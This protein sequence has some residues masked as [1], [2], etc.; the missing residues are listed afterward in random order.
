MKFKASRID[1]TPEFP[2]R[3]TGMKIQETHQ[4]LYSRLEMNAFLFYC[5]GRKVILIGIDTLFISTELKE[6]TLKLVRLH[7]EGIKDEDLILIATHTHFAPS[8]ERKRVGLGACDTVYFEFLCKRMELLLKQL[9]DA[10]FQDVD[11]EV[12]EGRSNGLTC[13]RRRFVRNWRTYF[14]PFI[15]MEPN[16]KGYKNEEFKLI[17]VV[18][19]SALR[20][21]TAL[22]WSFPCHPTNLYDSRLMSSEFP[23]E[24]RK[25]VREKEGNS[26]VPI[27]YLPGFAGDVRAFPPKRFSI[28]KLFRTIF[29]LPYPVKFYRFVDKQEYTNWVNSVELAFN[30]IWTSSSKVISLV[31]ASFETVLVKKDVRKL[32]IQ[33]EEVDELY[34]RRINWGNSLGIYTISAEPVSGYSLMLKQIASEQFYIVTGYSDVVF[35]YLPTNKQIEEGGYESK[36]HFKNFLISGEFNLS[37]EKEI[38]S[39]FMQLIT[40]RMNY[41]DIDNEKP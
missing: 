25:W 24:I 18:E 16:L 21:V 35:G 36:G 22:I 3:L 9:A 34:F 8:L 38:E 37:V 31:D 14:K 32:G 29:Q 1:I 10:S 20:S 7:E 11:L 17:K 39:G 41:G 6:Y 12:S 40:P 27:I 30:A 13:N 5:A 33:S 28:S 26:D 15:S 23:G 2:T 4:G 19:T